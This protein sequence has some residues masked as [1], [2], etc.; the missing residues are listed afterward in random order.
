VFLLGTWVGINRIITIKAKIIRNSIQTNKSIL[1]SL[2]TIPL[3]FYF[4]THLN[5]KKKGLTGCLLNMAW[6]LR[7]WHSCNKNKCGFEISW[8]EYENIALVS[9][10]GGGNPTTIQSQSQ[11]RPRRSRLNLELQ[12]NSHS[13]KISNLFV[14]AF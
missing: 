3:E 5:E 7:T 11:S 10:I 14:G 6:F 2:F 12:D 4:K 8:L 9:F 13:R 1:Y